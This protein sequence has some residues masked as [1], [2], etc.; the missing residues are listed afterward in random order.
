MQSNPLFEFGKKLY[1]KKTLSFSIELYRKIKEINLDDRCAKLG[2]LSKVDLENQEKYN[3]IKNNFKGPIIKEIEL[4]QRLDKVSFSNKKFSGKSVRELFV[5][6]ADD[7]KIII[8]KII[9]K[10]VMLNKAEELNLPNI[11]EIA[12]ESLYLYSTVAHQLGISRIYTQIEDISF[13]YLYTEEY[14]NIKS[15]ISPRIKTYEKKLKTMDKKLNQALKDYKLK[16]RTQFRVKRPYSIYRKMKNKDKNLE[17]I[18]DI[19]AIRIITNSINN[20]YKSLAVIHKNWIPI[21]GRFRDWISFPKPNGYRSLHTTILEK[22]DKYEIQIRTE[23]MHKEA[24]YGA[25]AHWSYK[26]KTRANNNWIKRLKNFLEN[27][28]LF[29]N[30]IDLLEYFQSDLETEQISVITP[31]GDLISLPEDS[32]PLDFAY[33]IHTDVGH[34]TTG[35]LVNNRFVNL[36]KKLNSGDIVEIITSKNQNPSRDWLEIARTSKAKSKIK[37]WL[38]KNEKMIFINKGKNI[39][40]QNIKRYSKKLDNLDDEKMLK[41]NLNK[42]G[43]KDLN[44][45]FFALGC[46][47][48]KASFPLFKKLFPL[49]SRET[50]INLT[51]Q[52]KIKTPFQ[53]PKISIE[54]VSNI[55]YN[56]GKCCK[57]IKGQSII[58]YVTKSSGIKIHSTKCKY[59]QKGVFDLKRIK[60]AKWVTDNSLQRIRIKI[61][62]NRYSDILSLLVEVAKDFDI[63]LDSIKEGLGSKSE[64]TLYADV[65]IKDI[66]HYNKFKNK[67]FNN[68]GINKA[69]IVKR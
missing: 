18:F 30:P 13:K 33:A 65:Y 32:S 20:C 49:K 31:K 55:E 22:K 36:K 29:E 3:L 44:S 62:G 10:L 56:L 28:D 19:M 14:S 61:Y 21:Q 26:E 23:E 43:Y 7:I 11:K 63:K 12:K 34:K 68:K 8:I 51:K 59:Y 37:Q 69:I 54:G 46:N 58:A 66:I 16:V 57:P 39:W 60:K 5:E 48:L 47:S 53:K 38:K 15:L 41:R 25:A 40:N 35:A 50:K 6:L 67:L 64:D 2:F 24:E 52:K 1:N 17:D 42:I 9:E 27:E 4:L 45:L